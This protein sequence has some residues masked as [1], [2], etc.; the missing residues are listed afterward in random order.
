MFPAQDPVAFIEGLSKWF[1]GARGGTPYFS[2]LEN[3]LDEIQALID[4]TAYKLKNLS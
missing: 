4:S 2:E 3:L 1:I